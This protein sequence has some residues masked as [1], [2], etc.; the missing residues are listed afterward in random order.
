MK[1]TTIKINTTG[2][3]F[4]DITDQVKK[5]T[6]SYLDSLNLSNKSG[7]LHIFMPHTSCGLTISEAFDP[8]AATD[9]ENFLKF[10][11]KRELPFITHKSEG[12]DDSPSH[13][14]SIMLDNSLTLIVDEGK[15]VLGTWQG[16]YLAEFRDGP[17]NRNIHL[18]FS[19]DNY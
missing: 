14:K 9:M 10:M 6:E 13:M 4:Y 11:A 16:I 5:S 1:Y 7:I 19:V 2:E 15:I 3:K 12:P 18:K 17:K 8:S